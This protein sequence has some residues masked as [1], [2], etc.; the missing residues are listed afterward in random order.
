MTTEVDG[1][2]QQSQQGEP[3][4]TGSTSIPK[5]KYDG[6]LRKLGEK[7]SELQTLTGKVQTLEEQLKN[8]PN[9]EE[10]NR[11]KA[12]LEGKTQELEMA[13]GELGKVTTQTADS[14][15]ASLVGKGIAEEKVKD[16]P[17]AELQRL[18]DVIGSIPTQKK[19]LPDMGVGGGS[20]VPSG[21]PME[22]SRQAYSQKT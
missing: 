17:I 22:L 2:S 13:K 15:R 1:K 20:G 7:D 19:P 14:L 11:I 12:D 4:G 16:M 18:A 6:V 8:A 10:F 5:E 9:T 21:S 3:E